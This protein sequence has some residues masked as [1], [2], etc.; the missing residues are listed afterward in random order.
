MRLKIQTET[1]T[2]GMGGMGTADFMHILVDGVEI[3]TQAASFD[4]SSPVITPHECEF[5]Y[6]CGVPTI[7]ARKIANHTVI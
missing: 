2:L 1:K 3:T 4:A 5:C 6:H 7:A